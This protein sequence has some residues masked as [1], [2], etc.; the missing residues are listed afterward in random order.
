MTTAVVGRAIVGLAVVGTRGGSVTPAPAAPVPALTVWAVDPGGV[1]RGQLVPHDCTI[2]ARDADVGTWSLTVDGRDELAQRL[3]PGWGVIIDDGLVRMSGR[4]E[5]FDWSA[6]RATLDLTIAGV[7]ELARLADRLIYPDPRRAIT[8]Q[9]VA[10]YKLSG[11]A[12]TVI[13]EMV[14]RNAGTAALQPRRSPRLVTTASQGRGKRVTVSE[15]MSNLLEVSRSLARIGGLTFTAVDDGTRILFEQHPP[16]DLSRQVRFT[17]LNGGLS[18]GEIGYKAPTV[19]AAIVAAQGEGVDRAITEQ[20]AEVDVWGRRIEDLFDRRDTSDDDVIDQTGTE[21]LAEGSAT[22]TASFE[23]VEVPGCVLGHDFQVGDTVTAQ[24]GSATVTEPV[25]AAEVSWDGH[26]RTVKL[27]LGDKPD[28]NEPAWV[29]R[30]RDL[31]TRL[32]RQ[33]AA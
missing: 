31:S 5:S 16:R 33:E 23:A 15:R 9:S 1:R 11:P 4:A 21:A 6:S 25:R 27:T 26:G 30:V 32:S 19:T 20:V 10:R 12:E 22:A 14:W 24:L 18:A 7:D 28:E 8:N 13:R 3:G 2:V 29:R 17:D